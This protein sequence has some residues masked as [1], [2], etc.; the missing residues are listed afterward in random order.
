MTTP[1]NGDLEDFFDWI[2][3]GMDVSMVKT[4][5]RGKRSQAARAGLKRRMERL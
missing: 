2:Q 1:I 3:S 4:D 5:I